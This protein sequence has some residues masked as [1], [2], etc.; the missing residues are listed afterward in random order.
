MGLINCQ[1][2]FNMKFES[3][4][5]SQNLLVITHNGAVLTCVATITNKSKAEL[6]FQFLNLYYETLVR[7]GRTDLIEEIY[8]TYKDMFEL[9][10]TPVTATGVL[11]IKEA[12]A[13]GAKFAQRLFDLHD[14]TTI[15]NAISFH[16]G[17]VFPDAMLHEYAPSTERN[18]TRE[19]TYTR[20]DYLELIS[21]VTSLKAT[22]PILYLID[23]SYFGNNKTNKAK[24]LALL[25]VYKNTS[26]LNN[27]GF[28]KLN[29]YI[30]VTAVGREI[31][32]ENIYSGISSEH[33]EE[34]LLANVF[35][36]LMVS[37]TAGS[38]TDNNNTIVSTI[39]HCVNQCLS[40]GNDDASGGYSKFK[41]KGG[42]TGDDMND[43]LSAL[44]RYKIRHD[45]APGEVVELSLITDSVTTILNDCGYLNL[46]KVYIAQ[47]MQLHPKLMTKKLDSTALT[48][49]S[50]LVADAC[51]QRTL[52]IV[53]KH[54]V[55]NALLAAMYIARE[56]KAYFFMLLFSSY[57]LQDAV[58]EHSILNTKTYA[59]VT[60]ENE[61][62]LKQYYP[63][64]YPTN[65]K[66]TEP[67]TN[68][69]MIINDINYIVK[70]L[71]VRIYSCIIGS[72]HLYSG[73]F[74]PK[75]I[76]DRYLQGNVINTPIDLKNLLAELIIG[77]V[78]RKL[79]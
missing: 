43:K 22:Q 57:L 11:T 19:Q 27:K 60:K 74:L 64:T 59:K 78:T 56:M 25:N 35:M 12:L 50:W 71:S 39:Y 75:D 31:S 15:Q 23:S 6:D 24:Y 37:T 17:L 44:E 36:K 55:I 53:P 41:E 70:E 34:W 30:G 40:D 66:T 26:Y 4:K 28:N 32:T 48:I 8:N 61:V 68:D 67:T 21:F 7:I 52:M 1:L 13:E 47:L 77:N 76:S 49:A 16:G 73:V 69:Y 58:E 33:K 2:G 65:K 5:N 63:Y 9:Y 79:Q 62:K 14:L 46:D 54:N 38:R 29:D 45:L 3:I 20:T 72:T 42:T 10:E 51:P 18:L